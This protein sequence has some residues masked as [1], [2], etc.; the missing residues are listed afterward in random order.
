MKRNEC[1]IVQDIIPLVIDRA[2][3][4]DSRELVENHIAVCQDCRS[5]YNAMKADLPDTIR[6]EYESERQNFVDA[7]K[8]VRKARLK[9][10]IIS[11]CLTS[12][13]FML[14]AFGGLFAYDRL[15]NQYTVPVDNALYSL[16]LSRLKDGRIIVTSDT[17]GITFNTLSK[18]KEV[19][20]D[21]KRIYYL[22]FLAA[23]IHWDNNTN[24]QIRQSKRE[25]NI[26]GSDNQMIHE[27]R[28]G[29]PD[30]Y[31]TIWTEGAPM[32]EAS[33]QME[34]YFA[35]DKQWEAWLH[36]QAETDDG[37]LIMVSEGFAWQDA[38]EQARLAVPE[39][40]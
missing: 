14:A 30:N 1:N 20:V 4:E 34:F 40:Q 9:R 35:L 27:I 37:K 12:L 33:E 19:S 5:K 21:G 24:D 15:V 32:A 3:C 18:A 23:P 17:F 8:N 22:Y 6:A 13:I 10:R 11:T 39:W 26:L 38:M 7:L 31:I 28:Q 25:M 16:S 29:T 2:A 36:E